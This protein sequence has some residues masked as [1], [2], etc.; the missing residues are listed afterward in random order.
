VEKIAIVLTVITK[1]IQNSTN[2]T[3]TTTIHKEIF[4]PM[5]P[6]ENIKVVHVEN[7]D[8][9]KNIVNVIK[10]D[11]FV[12]IFVNVYNVKIINHLVIKKSYLNLKEIHLQILIKLL[13]Y[14]ILLK[15]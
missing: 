10:Q 12:E 11:Y 15:I 2:T 4:S 5:I 6:Q 1:I 7:Q 9:Q 13:L 3:K 14:V 8:V